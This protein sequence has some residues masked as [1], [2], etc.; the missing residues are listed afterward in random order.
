LLQG[1]QCLGN[2]RE[3]V[4]R[5]VELHQ[6]L[7]QFIVGDG[8]RIHGIVQSFARDLPKW[9][10]GSHQRPQP[11]VLK[12]LFAPETGQSICVFTKGV[13]GAPG[14]RIKVEQRTV[15]IKDAG[16]WQT[17]LISGV[18]AVFCLLS[19]VVWTGFGTAIGRF[20]ATP[21]A[22]AVFNWAMAGLL[23]LSLVPVLWE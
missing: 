18:L 6:S 7:T 11:R 5:Q 20:I 8:K 3:W 21:R 9:R 17:S 4:E 19:C 14:G 2:F 1:P 23:V 16:L 15:G 22:R 12:L 13:L 10:I